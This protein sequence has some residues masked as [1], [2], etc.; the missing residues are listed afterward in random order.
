MEWSKSP[1]GRHDADDARDVGDEQNACKE[2]M[3]R[4]GVKRWM[5]DS[6]TET[7]VR[8]ASDP[9]LVLRSLS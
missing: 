9:V 5:L 1:N 8:H 6:V 2:H 3:R 4:S 7:V